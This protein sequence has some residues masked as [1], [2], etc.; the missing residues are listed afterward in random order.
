MPVTPQPRLARRPA[1]HRHRG[2]SLVELMVG[3]ALGL[4]IVAAATLVV[5]NQLGDNR[6]MLLEAQ[7]QQDL[8]AAAEIM[9]RELRRAGSVL[10]DIARQ[11]AWFPGAPNVYRNVMAPIQ[12]PGTAL[13]PGDICFNYV[14]GPTFGGPFGYR[15]VERTVAGRTVGVLQTN[16]GGP[17]GA[18]WQDLTDP[19]TLDITTL[20][21]TSAMPAAGVAPLALTCPELCADGTEDCWPRLHVRE[22]LVRISGRA[23]RDAAVQRTLELRVRPRSD[24]IEYRSPGSANPNAQVPPCP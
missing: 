9:A 18:N 22:I 15:R 17:A 3:M 10:D 23:T 12:I 1:Q 11:S 14:R 20:N 7:V 16:L 24:W 19:N 5:S 4:F 2:L 8:R 21:F 6:R 13:C